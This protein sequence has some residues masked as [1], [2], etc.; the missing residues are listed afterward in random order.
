[1]HVLCNPTDFLLDIPDNITNDLEP[2][3][4]SPQQLDIIL[5]NVE[6]TL[7][8]LNSIKVPEALPQDSVF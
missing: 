7:D 2:D 4:L 6:A 8:N 5:S 3:L 1:M